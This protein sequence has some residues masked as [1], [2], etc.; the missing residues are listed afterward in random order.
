MEGLEVDGTRETITIPAGEIGNEK[1]IEIVN[2]RWYSPDL[3]VVVRSTRS[4]PRLGVTTFRLKGVKREEPD[5]STF[6]VPE[7]HRI[8]DDPPPPHGPRRRPGPPEERP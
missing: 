7:D 8:T 5:R 6:L 1:P 3:Q 4:D 2:E